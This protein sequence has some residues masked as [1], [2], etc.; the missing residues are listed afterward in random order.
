MVDENNKDNSMDE[1]AC[2]PAA[3]AHKETGAEAPQRGIHW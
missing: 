2:D 1:A 3:G